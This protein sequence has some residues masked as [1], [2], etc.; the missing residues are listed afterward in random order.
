MKVKWAFFL[1]SFLIFLLLACTNQLIERV[2]LIE[3][4]TPAVGYTV[5]FESNGG[6]MV[7]SQTVAKGGTASPPENPTK[8]GYAFDDWYI[9]PDLTAVYDFETPVTAGITL[10]ANWIPAYTVTFMDGDKPLSAFTKA[11]AHDST[12]SRPATDPD[13]DGY[14]F[15][16]W[17]TNDGL[18]TLFDFN[19]PITGHTSVYAGWSGEEFAPGTLINVIF[20]VAGESEWAAAIS[21]I[22]DGG[23]D[24]NYVIEVQ[25]DFSVTGDHAATFG[26]VSG[27]TVSLRGAGRTLSLS[28]N[29]YIVSTED[30]QN[31]NIITRDLTLRGHSSNTNCLVSLFGGTFTMYGGKISGNNIGSGGVLVASGVTFTMNGGEISGNGNAHCQ[32]GGGV[33]VAS[34]GTFI[35]NG[36]EISGNAALQFGGGV[37]VGYSGTIRIV[38]GTI[39]G[40]DEADDVKNTAYFGAALYCSGTG[41]YGT[42]SGSKWDSNGNLDTTNDTIRVVNG[43]LQPYFSR[44][45]ANGDA[46]LT[47]TVLTLTFNR[48]IPGLSADDIV[49]TGIPG[50]TKGQ[51]SGTGPSYTLPISGFTEGGTL[52][53]SVS[54]EGYTV[55]GPRTAVIYSLLDMVRIPA[56][57]FTMGSPESEPGRSNTAGR[58]TQH[59][60]TLTK[61]FYMGK[62]EVTQAQYEAVTGS[63]PSSYTT[64][65]PPETST[66][67]R[68]VE[69]VSW[70]DAV[71]FCNKLSEK[72]GLTP[73]YTITDA[74]VIPNWGANGYRL[75]TEA[76]W[77][78]ACRAGTATAYNT[79]DTIS[80]DTGWYTSNSEG[81]THSVGEKPAN[82]YGLYDMHGNVWEWCWDWY[83]TYE[84]GAQTDPTGP[85][86]SNA[87]YYRVQRGGSCSSSGQSLRSASRDYNSPDYRTY[88]LGFRVVRPSD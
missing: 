24:R 27:V 48:A 3:E 54:K 8:D 77:E 19:T 68:P 38:T 81:R 83:G 25:S 87:G 36:G 72:E 75:P 85:N 80:D 34:G 28:G 15:H 7:D 50:V 61:D 10:Y 56:G 78:Y 31:Q 46:T 76:Q 18:T 13:R 41:Q 45:S 2:L 35:M 47:T 1:L 9:D 30:N 60:V 26:D 17:Y 43:V 69:N 65:V 11:V 5:A 51:L 63:K 58:E 52:S 88:T 53:V 79:G 29:G 23:N 20:N 37:D 22:K 55:G 57:T 40:S 66:A 44:V 42:F 62:Y 84:S 73:V 67:N 71:E 39:Y 74:M 6:S 82:A 86:N 70:Y 16:N 59:T 14:I 4:K 12:L 33:L 21:D 64:A 49:L 32:N